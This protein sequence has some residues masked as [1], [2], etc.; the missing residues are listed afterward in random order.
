VF[1]THDPR[2]LQTAKRVVEIS[3]GRVR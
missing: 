2:I 3:D 1:S